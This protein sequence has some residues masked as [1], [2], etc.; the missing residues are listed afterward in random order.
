MAELRRK[1]LDTTIEKRIVT[2]MIVSDKYLRELGPMIKWDYF[3]SSFTKTVGKWCIRYHGT[4]EKAPFDHI[5]DIY[6][7]KR[8]NLKD[9]EADL[10]EGLL[11]ELSDRHAYEGSINADYLLDQTIE[12][13]RKRELEITVGN[14]QILLDRNDIEGAEKERDKWRKVDRLYSKAVDPFDQSSIDEVFEDTEDFLRMQGDLGKFIGNMDRHYLVGITGPYKRGKTWFLQEIA[15]TAMMKRLKV[16]FFSLEMQSKQMNKR[17][18]QRLTGTPKGEGGKFKIPCFDCL[19]NQDD[20]CTLGLRTNRMRLLSPEGAKPSRF[21]PNSPYKTCT[22]CR[23]HISDA[24]LTEYW[25]QEVERPSFEPH[26]IT[27]QISAYRRKYKHYLKVIAYPRFGANTDDLLIDLD[28]LET[29]S[30]FVPDVIIID[31]ADILKPESGSPATGIE[32]ID[33]TWKCLARLAGERHALVVTATQATREALDAYHVTQ[34]HTSLWIGKLAHVDAML[35]LNQTEK[36]KE[37]GIMRVGVMAHRFE[38]FK[39]NANCYVLQNLEMG[40]T[41]LDSQIRRQ[42][43]DGD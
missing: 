43:A 37:E 12:Y 10:I 18:Y 13:F 39:Q 24:Y 31:Y 42:R 3:Q 16:A 40:Q 8:Q 25:Y 36:E 4:Y 20:S 28:R 26:Y 23:N 9:E 33:I 41:Y 22:A 2:G 15:I 32:A 7:E 29:G 1:R 6:N 17:I 34:K 21:D 11:K 35:S 27:T 14:M 5:E 19:R 30:E 38:D